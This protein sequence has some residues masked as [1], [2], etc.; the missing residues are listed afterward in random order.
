VAAA[1]AKK[2]QR[3]FLEHACDLWRDWLG[4]LALA[5]QEQALAEL[6]AAAR[7]VLDKT[8]GVPEATEP[9][10]PPAPPPSLDDQKQAWAAIPADAD[11]VTA[12]AAAFARVS[13]DA[14]DAW[15]LHAFRN[16]LSDAKDDPLLVDV[17]RRALASP[18]CEWPDT[19]WRPELVE[20]LLRLGR[21]DEARAQLGRV[22]LGA[23][24]YIDASWLAIIS[25]L[26]ATNRPDD[27]DVIFRVAQRYTASFDETRA[28]LA[29]KPP[30]DQ[31]ARAATLLADLAAP[32][33]AD[34]DA[35]D[36]EALDH[37]AFLFE[38]LVEE[39]VAGDALLAPA[40]RMREH[41]KARKARQVAD[42][43]A[44]LA[45]GEQLDE[46]A[47]RALI[48]ESRRALET[49]RPEDADRMTRVALAFP[50]LIPE[51]EAFAYHAKD[52]N[53]PVALAVYRLVVATPP[54]ADGDAR[55]SWL[56]TANS[57]LVITHEQ[58][59]Y[60]ESAHLADELARYARENP[61]ITHSA[62]CSYAAVERYDDALAMAKLAV[63]LDYDHLD[64]LKVDKDLGPL[65][66]RPE[67][68][69]LFA[70]R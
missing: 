26:D 5:E 45:R 65:L 61:Y 28:R 20:A 29:K 69:A 19:H 44:R 12:F 50:A 14:G 27:G 16:A 21:I 3:W 58:K 38:D 57:A 23:T 32:A 36:E 63:E 59:L 4:Q 13:D 66:K 68:K 67:F 25:Y 6:D 42:G 34:L 35:L 56:Q 7:A 24:S 17:T 39:D 43:F 52:S 37:G 15:D 40:K 55:T 30:K 33:L 10:P 1:L 18:S 51:L 49:A 46:S 47:L 31:K 8:G 22:V 9:A 60:A 2:T 64:K 53:L 48:K 11:A 62:A 41:G 54:P 70:R